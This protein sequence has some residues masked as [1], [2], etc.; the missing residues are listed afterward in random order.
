MILK[1]TLDFLK[2]LSENNYREWFHEHKAEYEA[3]KQNVLEVTAAML[4]EINKFDKS[5]ALTEPKKCL[6][7]IARDTRFANDKS[8]YKTNFGVIMNA[9]GSTRS[10]LSGYYMHIEQGNCFVSCG[11]YMPSPPVLKAIRTAIEEDWSVFS[12]IINKKAFKEAFGALFRDEDA[13]SRVPQGF[14]KDSPAAEFL[15]LK[16]F[17]V[18]RPITNK[19][20]CSKDYVSIAAHYYKLMQPL[21]SFLHGAVK[22]D[23]L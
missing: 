1:S 5:I 20:I 14:D 22:G 10:E 12:S 4:V 16:H 13:L 15:K 7:R 6:F 11:V 17:Y 18:H 2:Q 19:E 23:G 8:P 3:A 9:A 21:N